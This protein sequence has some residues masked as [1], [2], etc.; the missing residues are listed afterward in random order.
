M[1]LKIYERQ[2]LNLIILFV[3]SQEDMSHLNIYQQNFTIRY[4]TVSTLSKKNL[5]RIFNSCIS[6]Q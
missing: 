5:I 4:R 1:F 2:H 6:N 3:S